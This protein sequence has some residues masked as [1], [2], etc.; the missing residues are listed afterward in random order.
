M[1][2]APAGLVPFPAVIEG[3]W[4]PFAIPGNVR[5]VAT[6]E[7]LMPLGRVL[8]DCL[9][10]VLGQ[11]VLAERA[12]GQAGD[13]ILSP[14]FLP[15]EFQSSPEAYS[16][17]VFGDNVSVAGRTVA[18]SARAAARLLQLVQQDPETGSWSV[19]PVKIIDR[20]VHAWRGMMLDLARFPHSVED[21]K[22]GLDLAFLFSLN[23]VQLH[24]TDDQAFTFPASVLPP[25]TPAGRTGP[26]RG[27]TLDQLAELVRYAEARSITLV[28]EIEMPSHASALVRA[29]P[30]LFGSVDGAG[31]PVSTGVVNMASERAY[32]ALEDLLAEVAGVFSG[33]PV[34]HVGG[35]EVW[36]PNLVETPEFGPF[37]AAHGIAT[38]VDQGAVSELLGHFLG[39]VTGMVEELGMR[40][41]VWE[42]FQAPKDAARRLDKDVLVLAWSQQSRTPEDL[43]AAGYGVLNC[44]WD[45]LYIVPAQ[46]W[47][48]GL[49]RAYDWRPVQVRQRFGGREA[50]LPADARLEGAQICVW[51]QRPEAIVP[52]VLRVVPEIA[53]R[54]WGSW[55]GAEDWPAFAVDAELA[56][57]R[58]L[59][60][61]RP[62]S[63]R[64]SGTHTPM[65]TG[66]AERVTLTLETSAP[67]V[68]RYV[69]AEDYGTAVRPNARV[70]RGEPLVLEASAVVSARL[71]S[72]QGRPLG[73]TT[74]VRVER[75]R[76]IW[77]FDAFDMPASG[78]PGPAG[79]LAWAEV[80]GVQPIGSG[81]LL[82]PT[83]ERIADINREQFAKVQP[84]NHVDTRPLC[85]TALDPA[86]R[87]DPMRSRIWGRH[88]LRMRAQLAIPAAGTY[89]L[90]AGT[91]G[92]VARVRVAGRDVLACGGSEETASL[93]LD[94]GVYALEIDYAML[95][96]HDDLQ[97]SLAGPED[98]EEARPL[99]S[100]LL[101]VPERVPDAELKSLAE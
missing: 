43:L 17:E 63:I 87:I 98:G 48:A 45:P 3:R 26:N 30:D 25:R 5:I 18:G 9:G 84:A 15:E 36:A 47:A 67:G 21:V 79:E 86:Q 92:S 7:E 44:G 35:D 74:Q 10:R 20:P 96:V 97:A 83:R 13:I 33:S 57:E 40:P 54:L 89:R 70:Y 38:S 55:S 49:E 61:L 58:A 56:R 60:V 101:S 73:G 4:E 31:E 23:T 29:R 94:Q 99:V 27:Y 77:D 62:V 22:E 91:R 88:A 24:L 66:F 85:W 37:A 16:I 95:A 82:D 72:D 19:P 100:W 6:S 53:E 42:G 28:P 8:A 12:P 34:L 93:S 50:S 41:A 64:A 80:L 71:Y 65:G 78:A 81:L 52:G 32:A 39:R 46:G 59:R 2:P 69:V 14:G 75:G 11:I 68:M 90:R 76:A 51:E 1:V